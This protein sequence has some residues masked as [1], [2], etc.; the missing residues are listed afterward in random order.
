M[1]IE[2]LVLM[3]FAVLVGS[4]PAD[5]QSTQLQKNSTAA[6]I[7][8]TCT[9]EAMATAIVVHL[10]PVQFAQDTSE[11]KPANHWL[12]QPKQILSEGLIGKLAHKLSIAGFL[13]RISDAIDN[14]FGTS[15]TR[16]QET[17]VEVGKTYLQ[18]GAPSGPH[19][20]QYKQ[21]I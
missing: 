15:S 2:A 5:F 9:P 6:Q 13:K 8:T 1:M 14:V 7:T 4:A 21:A 11:M 16:S 19:L 18:I 20:V 3:L 12:E 10:L 17:V